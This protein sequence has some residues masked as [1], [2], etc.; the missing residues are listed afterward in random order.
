M[1]WRFAYRVV[2]DWVCCCISDEDGGGALKGACD[3]YVKDFEE[4]RTGLGVER[5]A[6]GTSLSEGI[7]SEPEVLGS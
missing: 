7:F 2:C 6:R 3:S 1:V 5:D 4:R